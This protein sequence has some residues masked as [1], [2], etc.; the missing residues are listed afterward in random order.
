[1]TPVY[2]DDSDLNPEATPGDD[3]QQQVQAA[4]QMQTN[5][6]APIPSS[7]NPNARPLSPQEENSIEQ[8]EAQFE[9]EQETLQTNLSNDPNYKKKLYDQ[10]QLAQDRQSLDHDKQSESKFTV[11]QDEAK[12]RQDEAIVEQDRKLLKQDRSRL[13]SESGQQS[14]RTNIP[15]A[16]QSVQASQSAQAQQNLQKFQAQKTYKPG[17]QDW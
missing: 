7:E 4:N 12:V 11:E 6:S 14:G 16:N 2:A 3:E 8:A 13:E 1:M 15:S 10:N 17:A 9:T 5:N